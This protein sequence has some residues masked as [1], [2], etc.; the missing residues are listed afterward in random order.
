MRLQLAEDERAEL[1]LPSAMLDDEAD[2]DDDDDPMQEDEDEMM[3]AMLESDL[4]DDSSSAAED[5][6]GSPVPRKALPQKATN[7]AVTAYYRNLAAKSMHPW[8][9]GI[10]VPKSAASWQSEMHKEV[11]KQ[12]NRRRHELCGTVAPSKPVRYS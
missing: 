2:D 10:H 3:S 6:D 8:A 1:L 12:T 4:S 5:D 7:Q 11:L 9:D